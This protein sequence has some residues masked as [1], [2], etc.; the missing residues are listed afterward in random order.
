MKQSLP[1]DRS[2]ITLRIST[3]QPPPPKKIEYAALT[4]CSLKYLISKIEFSYILKRIIHPHLDDY[5]KFA[6]I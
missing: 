2:L 6:E 4:L 3:K 1:F 5:I